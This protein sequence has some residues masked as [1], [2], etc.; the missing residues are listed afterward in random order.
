MKILIIQLARLGDIFT[1]WPAVRAL[2]RRF[3]DATIEVLTRSKFAEAWNGCEAVSRIHIFD[4]RAIL[5]PIVESSAEYV[6][7]YRRVDQFVDK[8]TDE[9]YDRIINLTFSPASSY[10]AHLISAPSTEVTGYTR[11]ADGYLQ[12]PDDMSA[13]FY[14]QV[15]PTKPNRFHLAEIFATLAGCDLIPQDWAP[16]EFVE[17]DSSKSTKQILV[18]VG[19]SESRKA[20]PA[21]KWIVL[22]NQLVKRRQEKIVLIG[23]KNEQ[24]IAVKIMNSI[25][26]SRVESQVGKT[27][28]AE[29]FQLIAN[30]ALVIGCDSAPMH[31]AS[32]VGTK[33]FNISLSAVNFWETGPRSIPSA[34]LRVRDENDLVS[35]SFAELCS[36]LLDGSTIPAQLARAQV[37]SPSYWALNTPKQ[38][39]KWDLVQAIYQGVDFPEALDGD[40]FLQAVEKLHEVNQLVTEQLTWVSNGGDVTKVSGILDRSEEVIDTI[41]KI[42]E[43]VSPLVR[44]YQ[45]EKLRIGPGAQKEVLAQTLH[46]HNLMN[47]VLS[48][49]SPAAQPSLEAP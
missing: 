10:I 23:A 17:F 31:M 9:K 20:L 6:E 12:I 37:G 8:L 34:V 46:I 3:P 33:C 24:E 38:D 16:P 25:P 42:C 18:H 36:S 5:G 14:A 22:I 32:L 11:F 15:G 43:T 30:S 19:A 2:R 40:H 44:W 27:T 28:L 7:S 21:E 49:Y 1:S 39:F 41:G 47:K 45:T 35:D 48:L 13:Y 26:S 29:L 4:S